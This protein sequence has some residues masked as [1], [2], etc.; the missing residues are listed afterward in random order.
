MYM[1]VGDWQ[2]RSA[3][4]CPLTRSGYIQHTQ[5]QEY[6][7]TFQIGNL[8]VPDRTHLEDWYMVCYE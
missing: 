5:S 2:D 3:I 8:R 7:C 4:S 6:Q 1:T